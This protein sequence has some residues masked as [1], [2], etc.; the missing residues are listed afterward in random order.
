VVLSPPG[1]SPSPVLTARLAG[2]D[3]EVVTV[4]DPVLAMSQAALSERLSSS[5]AA[6]GLQSATR[7]AMILDRP[8]QTPELED[9]VSA[10]GAYLD[11]VAVIVHDPEDEH[12]WRRISAGR[13]RSVE[14]PTRALE[15]HSGGS[16]QPSDES[17]NTSRDLRFADHVEGGEVA[18]IDCGGEPERPPAP[19][20]ELH[21]GRDE[22]ERPPI[23]REELAMLLRDDDEAPGEAPT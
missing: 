15:Q 17:V 3:V 14:S 8:E 19:A 22:D 21:H 5:R 23:S 10:C 20:D 11:G 1:Q 16:D 4:S 2:E 9:L 13:S 18:P 6:W 12:H 7:I